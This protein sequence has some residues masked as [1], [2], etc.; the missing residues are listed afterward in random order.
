MHISALCRNDSALSPSSRSVT[1]TET[2]MRPISTLVSAHACIGMPNFM[3]LEFIADDAPWR[4]DVMDPPLRVEDGCLIPPDTPGLGTQLV[5][6]E[7]E[8]YLV[9]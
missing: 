7:V 3:V 2:E 1:P 8:K 6:K 9:E 5:M 4:D